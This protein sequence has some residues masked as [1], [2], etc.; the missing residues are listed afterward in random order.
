L[1][2][3][4]SNITCKGSEMSIGSPQFEVMLIEESLLEKNMRLLNL[5][6]R[7]VGGRSSTFQREGM[8][9]SECQMKMGHGFLNV[10]PGNQILNLDPYPI[11]GAR[12]VATKLPSLS[13]P[14]DQPTTHFCMSARYSI[15][16]CVLFVYPFCGQKQPS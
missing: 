10:D 7:T 15:S 11:L 2:V 16:G 13:I 3:P 4:S 5:T 14:K 9:C 1:G 12:L 6:F 8:E